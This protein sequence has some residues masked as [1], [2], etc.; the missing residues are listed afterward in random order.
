MPER[1]ADILDDDPRPS[2]CYCGR[3]KARSAAW[4]DHCIDLGERIKAEIAEYDT[5]PPIDEAAVL[6]RNR[7]RAGPLL[8]VPCLWCGGENGYHLS[9]CSKP[10]PKPKFFL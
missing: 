3:P 7:K 8:E 6:L 4:C 9:T 2:R 5:R 10:G 1:Y